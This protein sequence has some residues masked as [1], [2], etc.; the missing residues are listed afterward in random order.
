M[1]PQQPAHV[2]KQQ[3]PWTAPIIVDVINDKDLLVRFV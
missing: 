2:T 3:I 1:N